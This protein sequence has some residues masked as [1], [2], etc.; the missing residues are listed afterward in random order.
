MTYKDKTFC[1]SEVEKHTCGRELT[2][3]DENRAKELAMPIAFSK[4]CEEN[5]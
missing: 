5:P 1:A 2:K 3:E 4:F